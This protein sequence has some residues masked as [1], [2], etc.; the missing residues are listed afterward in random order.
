MISQSH[1]DELERVL[2]E[3]ISLINKYSKITLVFPEDKHIP[4]C[5]KDAFLKTIMS[6]L[7]KMKKIPSDY[8]N[9]THLPEQGLNIFRKYFKKNPDTGVVF[10]LSPIVTMAILKYIK[11]SPVLNRTVNLSV[12]IIDKGHNSSL[13][14][15]IFSSNAK[16]I[17]KMLFYNNPL[18]IFKLKDKI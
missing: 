15:N 18:K 17:A 2:N 1:N 14:I 3:G 9:A 4:V 13:G 10:S 5:I 12:G 6:V 7:K 11:E 16:E 8:I